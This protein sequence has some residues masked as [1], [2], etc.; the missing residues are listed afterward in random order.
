M[1]L[2]NWVNKAE[3]F[4]PGFGASCLPQL[5]GMLRAVPALHTAGTGDTRRSL[6]LP[7]PAKAFRGKMSL[8]KALVTP[9]FPAGGCWTRQQLQEGSWI[10]LTLWVHLLG[11]FQGHSTDDITSAYRRECGFHGHTS[12]PSISLPALPPSTQRIH[13]PIWRGRS[14]CI[15]ELSH[16]DCSFNALKTQLLAQ[17][18]SEKYFFLELSAFIQP[19]VFRLDKQIQ[20]LSCKIVVSL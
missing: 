19:S 4:L 10:V 13:F 6:E 7:K 5:G 2:L 3:E 16:F 20:E 18:R 8:C 1:K 14:S 11:H 12:I 15:S 9:V 17:L